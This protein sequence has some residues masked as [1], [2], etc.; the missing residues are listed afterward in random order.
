MRRWLVRIALALGIGYL[1]LCGLLFVS[2]ESLLFRPRTLPANY[3]FEGGVENGLTTPDGVTLSLV[4]FTHPEPRGAILYFHGNVGN[5]RRSIY[6]TQSLAEGEYDL[7][8]Y[9][10][11]GYGKSGGT[12]ESEA[13]LL[14]DAQLVFDTLAARYG[15]GRVVLV[16]YSLGTG[17]ASYLAAHNA[18]QHC[19]LVAPYASL[20]GM[21][22]LWLWAVPDFILQYPMNTLENIAAANCPVTVLHGRNDELIPYT[23]AEEIRNVAPD[24]VTLI[25]LPGTGH[26]GAILHA[27]FREVMVDI[28]TR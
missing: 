16:G 7:Y 28:L 9:D 26:R 5:N 17:M 6:Q 24:K 18:P 21:K 27:R 1:L 13:Q 25:E 19:V 14:A 2:Q 22:N 11:R 20:T 15:A 8:L 4:S 3:R 12:I 10:Y 23:M